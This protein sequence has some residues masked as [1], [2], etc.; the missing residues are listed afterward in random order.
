M[1]VRVA[2]LRPPGARVVG[3]A[4]LACER[5]RR[6]VGTRVDDRDGET[7]SGSFDPA[8]HSIDA[9]RVV[10]PLS[11]DAGSR[12][13][14]QIGRPA[15]NGRACT[16][17][18]RDSARRPHIDGCCSQGAY[19][20]N[21]QRRDQSHQSGRANGHRTCERRARRVRHFN[22]LRRKRRPTGGL[23]MEAGV[24][25][26]AGQTERRVRHR[27]QPTRCNPHPLIQAAPAVPVDWPNDQRRYLDDPG[28][29]PRRRS[30]PEAGPTAGT[31]FCQR[32]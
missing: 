23:R 7:C 18:T 12:R 32:A 27:S 26:G 29:R 4:H 5:G 6:D 31:G 2:N 20:G 10:L 17:D 19:F 11:R 25:R 3:A 22:G 14:L 1:T 16:D 15:R 9:D 28:G 30:P 21:V 13:L 8:R 24:T